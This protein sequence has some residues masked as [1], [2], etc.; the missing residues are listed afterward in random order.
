MFCGKC[1][2]KLR[3]YARFCSSCGAPLDQE[4]LEHNITMQVLKSIGVDINN[5]SDAKTYPGWIIKNN[6]LEIE[7]VEL[8]MPSSMIL[9][10]AS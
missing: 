5:T 3:D 6:I 2:A 9:A 8:R 10:M 7:P 1:G 4:A